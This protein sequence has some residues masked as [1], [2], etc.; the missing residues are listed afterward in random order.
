MARSQKLQKKSMQHTT[1][2]DGEEATTNATT[3]TR[4]SR[5]QQLQ[6]NLK[7]LTLYVPKASSTK[8]PQHVQ[9]SGRRRVWK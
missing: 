2:L 5:V 9:N 7:I 1:E 6:Q 4:Y 3:K 8:T